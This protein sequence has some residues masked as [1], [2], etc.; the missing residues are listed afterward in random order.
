VKALFEYDKADDLAAIAAAQKTLRTVGYDTKNGSTLDLNF[1]SA[2]QAV[3]G[4]LGGLAMLSTNAVGFVLRAAGPLATYFTGTTPVLPASTDFLEVVD[5]NASFGDKVNY[6]ALAV[7]KY[8]PISLAGHSVYL[9]T[10]AL[11]QKDWDAL[12]NESYILSQPE[13]QG[14]RQLF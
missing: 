13:D 7:L 11:I 8:N 6:V 4:A 9:M 1:A 10:Q 3:D 5:S 12:R 14:T 2:A